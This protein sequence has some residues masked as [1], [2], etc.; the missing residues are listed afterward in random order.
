MIARTALPL[1]MA[2][3]TAAAPEAEV[4]E[5]RIAAQGEETEITVQ[6]SGQAEVRDFLLDD[7]TRLVVDLEGATHALPRHV[8]EGVGRGGVVGL[9]TSQFR[10]DVVRLVFEL[11]GPVDYRVR[12]ED[13]AVRIRFPNPGDGFEAWS[14]AS[15]GSPGLSEEVARQLAA[16]ENG[17]SGAAGGGASDGEAG[18]APDRTPADRQAQESEQPRISVT[19]DSASMLDV[20]AGF[21]E[22]SGTSI[23]PG[24]GV[25]D[26]TVRGVDI[27]NQPWDVALDA[28]LSSQGL[29]WRRTDSGI[30]LVD[31]LSEL[32]GRDTLQTETRV[33]RINYAGADTV[34]QALQQ[35][36]SDRGKVVAYQGTNSVIVTDAPSAVSRMDSLVQVLDRRTAQVSIEAKIIFV[37]R[38][39]VNALGLAYDLKEREGD[40]TEQAINDVVPSP[41]P[42]NPG[43]TTT[44]TV[45]NF[46]GNA[47]SAVANANARVAS[48]ALSI[49]ASTAFGDF[50]LF[51]FV[52][53]L[54]EHRLSDVQAAPSIQVVDNHQ[55]RIQVG[56]RTPIRVLEPQAQ[57]SNA[58]VNVQFEDTGIILEVTPHITNNNQV[59]LDLMAERSDVAAGPSD[60]GFIFEKQIGETRLL[61]DDGETA[62]IG[63]LTLSEVTRSESGIPGLMNLPLVGGLFRT[64]NENENKRDLI[65][66]VTPH[67]VNAPRDGSAGGSTPGAPIPTGS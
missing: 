46:G 6:T 8:Y 40:Q 2:L 62:V 42:D 33:L 58:Q 7:P 63:G 47:I 31:Q 10:D 45:V 35:L 9:R 59:L 49:L 54:E 18:D 23:V 48:P 37:D 4:A 56:E 28:I 55:A 15:P 1:L 12:S 44:E 38:T 24:S 61:L 53:A 21:A 60:I 3:M 27:Q 34:A 51:A 57:L 30:L 5:V 66:L 16:A 17:G 41:D 13:G 67:I 14:T 26:I 43:E 11:S 52:D 25:S 19:Y 65:I 50:S 29:G 39:N 22:F 64:A 20:I 36:A 32:R